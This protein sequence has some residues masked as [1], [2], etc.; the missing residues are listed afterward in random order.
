MSTVN[1]AKVAL[2]VP[3]SRPVSRPRLWL[4]LG[5]A[6]ATGVV[7]LWLF[8][9]YWVVLTSFKPIVE[10][11]SAIP[12]FVFEPTLENYRDL[13]AKFEFSGV[14]LNSIVVTVATCVV[15]VGLGVMAAYAL[16]RLKVP[17]EKHLALWILSLRF[18]PPIAVA[19]PFYIQWQELNLLDTHVGLIVVYVAFN[20]PFAIWLLRGFLADV[21]I[22]LEEAALLDGLSRLQILWRV[23][24]P[25][26]LPGLA[27]TSIFIFVFTWNE[28]LMALMLTS[29]NAV[30]VPVTISKFVMPYTILWGDLSAAVVIQLVPMLAV[31]FLLQ[32]HI[33]RGMT[34]G[35]VK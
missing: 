5:H 30:T 23:V 18:L 14:L 33:V 10:I 21:P 7:L 4:R 25:V 6:A 22:E 1:E 11:N 19:I 8:P 3:A 15:V 12:S 27:S 32:R 9:V 31:V 17:G 34:L 24:V 26:I 28:Y 20:L 35:A 13:F 29:V 16:A 2:D